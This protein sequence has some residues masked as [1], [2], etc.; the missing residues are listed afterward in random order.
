MDAVIGHEVAHLQK[1]HIRM[2]LIVLFVYVGAML[3]VGIWLGSRVPERFPSGPVFYACMP[4][5]IF[6]VSRL[7]NLLPM[8]APRS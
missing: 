4:V 8:P 7:T 6:P 1:K 2:R 3:G 5:T